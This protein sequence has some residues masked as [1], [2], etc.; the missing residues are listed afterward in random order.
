MNPARCGRVPPAMVLALLVTACT[1]AGH[2][3]YPLGAGRGWQY[4]LEL[5]T[6]GE[7]HEHKLVVRNL[8]AGTFAGER[9]HARREQTGDTR[10]YRRTATGV[11]R[12][13]TRVAGKLNAQAD[14][15]GQLV[16]PLPAEIG[17]RWT[18][19]SRLRL[20]E[21]RTFAREDRLAPR[22]LPVDIDYTLEA[23]DDTVTV[24]AGT[25]AHCLR[26]RGAGTAAVPVDRGNARA[27]V[28]VEHVEWYAPDVGLVKSVRHE[29]TDS[30][31]LHNGDYRL[32]LERYD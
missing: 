14:P 28:A 19:T 20:V 1:D 21:S 30:V 5:R 24:A 29:T 9:V 8:G 6:L 2:D 26:I 23:L 27:T 12:V 4:R 17:R 10:Y 16:L 13:A 3:Y 18:L 25:F 15:P 22:H 31:F 7:V 11:V 32:E